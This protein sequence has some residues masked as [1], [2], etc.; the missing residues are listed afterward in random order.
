MRSNIIISGV[1]GQGVVTLGMLIS[2]TA[3]AMGENVVMSEIHGLAQ[4]GG[5]VS[6]DIRIG[7]FHA[8]II[9]SGEVDLIIGMEPIEARRVLDRAEK[10][11]HVIVNLEKL[12]PV[13][14]SIRHQEYPELNSLIDDIMDEFNVKTI[15]AEKIGRE[16]GN[17]RAANV[18]ILGFAIGTG[19][20]PLSEESARE[21]IA[22][23]F[24]GRALDI[25]VRAFE[26]GLALSGEKEQIKH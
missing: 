4:R 24:S 6:V 14:L 7:D 23:Q 21:R 18:A 22:A 8:P 13:S 2:Q 10:G 26:S 16:A 25:N 15:D 5:S 1:G 12:V 9:P 19:W 3:I 17:Y 11:T 20:L